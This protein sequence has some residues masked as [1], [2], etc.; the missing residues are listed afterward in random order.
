MS[1]PSDSGAVDA[2][3]MQLALSL[4]RR[5]LGN[6]YPNPAVGAVIVKDG[7]IVGR[8]WTQ[9]GGRPHAEVE[10]LRQAKKQAKGATLYCTL[11]PCSHEG[12]SPPCA[13]AIIKAGIARV[14]SALEDPN[15]EV[16][17]QGHARMRDK[18]ITV[19][20][21]L[22][23]EEAC[24][25]HAGHIAR[26][27][28]SRPHVTFKLA[29]SS[30]GKA[31]LA[32][33]KRIAITGEEARDR[34]WLMRGQ[35]DAILVGIGTVLADD[36]DLTCRLDGYTAAATTRIVADSQLR[37]PVHSRL[38]RS[39]AAAPVWV[40]T[41]DD[42]DPHQA[43][44]LRAAGVTLIPVAGGAGGVAMAA[45]L[46]ALGARGLTSVLIEGGAGVAAS[47]LQADLIDR[48]AWFHAPMLFGGD[49]WPAALP[50]GIASLDAAP[51]FVRQSATCVG[52]DM[53]TEFVR[54]R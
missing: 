37:L 34:V 9:P 30:D 49:G 13:D 42:A 50:F 41:R 2:R 21:G 43:E 44:A 38:V 48:V 47:L 45:G 14:V 35:S 18:G 26:I 7:V 40:L 39:A 52:D 51:R 33:R 12:K 22:M 11:E 32:G 10:A 19:D 15:P 53:L 29:V 23:A 1:Q 5:G 54:V 36:P 16:A 24:R 27:Q 17:G 6:A 28:K 3:Y 46:A 31:G 4:G 25:A 20:V 8:G